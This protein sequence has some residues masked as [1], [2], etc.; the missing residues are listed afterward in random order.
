[1]E[2][3]KVA[4]PG[5]HTKGALRTKAAAKAAH[6]VQLG[7]A[8]AL[9]ADGEG[10]PERVSKLVEGCTPRQIKYALSKARADKAWRPAWS[11][12]TPIEMQRLVKWLLAS[13][14]NDNPAT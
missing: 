2:V 5:T 4:N 10:G 7:K 11:I 6:Q 12:M 1:M 14:A 9:V 3:A 8:V 13:A